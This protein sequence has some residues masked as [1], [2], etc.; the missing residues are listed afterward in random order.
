[1]EL[2]IDNSIDTLISIEHFDGNNPD[3]VLKIVNKAIEKH[4]QQFTNALKK[5]VR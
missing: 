2:S 4:D 3:D 1:M 5:Y